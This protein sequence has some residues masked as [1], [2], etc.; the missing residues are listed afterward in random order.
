V[1]EEEGAVVDGGAPRAADAPGLHERPEW[2]AAEDLEEHVMGQ[3]VVAV[4]GLH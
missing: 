3:T 2:E 1:R 4:V